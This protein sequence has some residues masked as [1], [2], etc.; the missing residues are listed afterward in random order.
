M[1]EVWVQEA[2]HFWGV[3]CC[4]TGT[5]NISLLLPGELWSTFGLM[6][7]MGET[8]HRCP[9][10]AWMLSSTVVSKREEQQS[11]AECLFAHDASHCAVISVLKS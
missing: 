3:E 5:G 6:N 7:C 10:G 2:H 1:S 4:F 8:V 11:K 9:I